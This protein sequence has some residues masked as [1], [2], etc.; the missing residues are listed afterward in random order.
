[1]YVYIR[2]MCAVTFLW[3]NRQVRVVLGAVDDNMQAPHTLHCAQCD[4]RTAF[5]L[6]TNS[7]HGTGLHVQSVH[8]YAA[9]FFLFVFLFVFSALPRCFWLADAEQ[10]K[11]TAWPYINF[12]ELLCAVESTKVEKHCLHIVS[13][14]SSVTISV[15][16]IGV[17]RCGLYIE[18]R[19]PGANNLF[20]SP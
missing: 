3:F 6:Q 18:S 12:S 19:W 4:L 20:P 9:C 16:V 8:V 2:Y 17:C 14:F 11:K 5:G 10:E 1:M 15:R 7:G 13:S